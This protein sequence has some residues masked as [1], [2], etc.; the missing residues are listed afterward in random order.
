MAAEKDYALELQAMGAIMKALD[1]LDHEARVSVLKWVSEKLGLEQV[2]AS[3]LGDQSA[4]PEQDSS[5]S[6]ASQRAGTINTVASKLGADSCRTVLISAAVHLTLFQGKDAFSR[7][8][9]VNLAK[10]AKVWKAD[11]INQTSTMIG[12]LADAGVLVEKSKD[13]YFLSDG[14]AA[15]FRAALG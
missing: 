12:R 14:A 8:E 11:Y 9:L 10:S 4:E 6:A 1:P 13:T 5:R 2:I 7:A 3:A 15:E